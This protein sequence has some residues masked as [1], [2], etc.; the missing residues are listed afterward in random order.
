[1]SVTPSPY[2][3]FSLCPPPTVNAPPYIVIHKGRPR[4]NFG[5]LNRTSLITSELL[6]RV[7]GAIKVQTK[8]DFAPYYGIEATFT[9][10]T[11]TD[12]PDWSKYVPLI[13]VDTL[14]PTA[15]DL[16]GTL[17][18]H[19]VQVTSLTNPDAP[20]G[21]AISIFISNPPNV[22]NGL[23]YAIIPMGTADSG[24]GVYWDYLQ[25]FEGDFPTFEA[26]LTVTT[27]HEVLE[28]LG[29]PTTNSY[30]TDFGISNTVTRFELNIMEVC[31]P[32][33]FGP[34]Y[35][36]LIDS[37][38]YL[39]NFVLPSYWNPYGKSL[40]PFDF[41]HRVQAPL[42]PYAGE[43]DIIL[44]TNGCVVETA[45]KISIPSDPTTIIIQIG[46]PVFPPKQQSN[47]S[48]AT[49]PA[50]NRLNVFRRRPRQRPLNNTSK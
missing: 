17:G 26:I 32:V 8:K 13:F 11:A 3:P 16:T 44:I 18:F 39:S 22:P 33:E 20:G 19:D 41:L 42:T 38:L 5:V 25:G 36:S 4:M 37:G 1:M 47:K 6:A 27:S 24:Y 35:P 29:D 30:I 12:Q 43:Q 31:D 7:L 45:A 28:V 14:L 50:T 40:G 34:G 23:P 2:T 10:F 9:I 46:T 21:N 48:A 15:G 49:N